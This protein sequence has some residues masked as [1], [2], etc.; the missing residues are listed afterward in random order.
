MM[1]TGANEGRVSLER[2]VAARSEVPA[3]V[4]GLWPRK[5]HLGI[6]ADADFVLVDMRAEKTLQD[7]DVVSK[8][9]WTPFRGR[10]VKG[11]PLMTFVRGRL[12]AQDGQP[13]IEPGWGEYVPGPGV[14][15]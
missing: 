5:G 3:Q 15:G 4:Y 13:V 2:L 6:G 7:E 12:V 10:T 11:L 14:R 9:G 1:L 8:V